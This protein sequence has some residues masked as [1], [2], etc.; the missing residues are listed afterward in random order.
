[1]RLRATTAAHDNVAVSRPFASMRRSSARCTLTRST[2]DLSKP[3]R[4]SSQPLPRA[5]MART[6]NRRAYAR[7]ANHSSHPCTNKRSIYL[8][9]RPIPTSRST[10]HSNGTRSAAAPFINAAQAKDIP[11]A[12]RQES[13]GA[14]LE[15]NL[16]YPIIEKSHPQ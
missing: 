6:T 16:T 2:A 5:Q 3:R 9:L 13:L 1:M 12:A 7:S 11:T 10:L 15:A 14:T 8:P 4:S